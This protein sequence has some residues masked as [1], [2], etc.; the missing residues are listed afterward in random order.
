MECLL[1]GEG[2]RKYVINVMI[3]NKIE[4]G[5]IFNNQKFLEVLNNGQS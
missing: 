3:K 2:I 5:Y 4:I 1:G